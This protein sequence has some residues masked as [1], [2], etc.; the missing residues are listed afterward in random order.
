VTARNLAD[1]TLQNLSVDPSF[2]QSDVYRLINTFRDVDPND[3][4][5]IRTETL[6]TDGAM[7]D[8]QSVLLVRKAEAEPLLAQLRSFDNSPSPTTDQA[9]PSATKVRVV[10]ASG[11][12]GI[13]AQALD[14][15]VAKGFIG[16]GTGNG[17]VR[18][19]Q[20]Q[21]L[22]GPGNKAKAELVASYFGGNVNTR[23]DASVQGTDVE[24][25]LG[26]SFSGVV[27]PT[28]TTAPMASASSTGG[29]VASPGPGDPG[30]C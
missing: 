10:N 21:V 1:K 29:A 9:K 30:A 28:S 16:A 5:R 19:A 8:G 26:T 11:Q 18:I 22:Y 6:P 23:E 25:Q 20:T 12:T 17:Q 13:A 27:A 2:D 24:V 14:A 4:E 3:T 7:R 15:L